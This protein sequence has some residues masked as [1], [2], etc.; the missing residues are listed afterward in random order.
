MT[1][2]GSPPGTFACDSG[3]LKELLGDTTLNC[4][5]CNGQLTPEKLARLFDDV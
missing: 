4:P 5:C 3:S 2:I 1:T